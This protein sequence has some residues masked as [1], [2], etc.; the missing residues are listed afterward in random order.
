MQRI[1]LRLHESELTAAFD[2]GFDTVLETRREGN[3][4]VLCHGH[5][6]IARCGRRRRYGQA[7]AGMLW[8]KQFDYYDVDRWL[9]ERGA[10]RR[11]E[12]VRHGFEFCSSRTISDA[13]FVNCFRPMNSHLK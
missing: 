12:T 5:S 9:E 13:D 2:S 10:N 3:G 8:S 4:R 6:S 11:Y 7:L 1:R